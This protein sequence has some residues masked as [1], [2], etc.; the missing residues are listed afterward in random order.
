MKCTKRSMTSENMRSLEEAREITYACSSLRAQL[1]IL[2]EALLQINKCLEAG[3]NEIKLKQ[4]IICSLEAA[5]ETKGVG[6]CKGKGDQTSRPA[7]DQLTKT[8]K[9]AGSLKSTHVRY[10]RRIS[11][12][13]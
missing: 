3:L 11:D 10:L 9:L 4:E 7:S 5:Q 2:E 6:R 1:E 12:F 8:G 13:P